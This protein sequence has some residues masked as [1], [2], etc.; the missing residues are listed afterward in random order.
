MELLATKEA[1]PLV[2]L[3]GAGI[4]DFGFQDDLPK[5]AQVS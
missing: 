3:H 1:Q 2:Q 5:H 4:G